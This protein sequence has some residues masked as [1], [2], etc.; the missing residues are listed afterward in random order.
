MRR[1]RLGG[2]LYSSPSIHILRAAL[3]PRQLTRS[4]LWPSQK[5][6]SIREALTRSYA[7]VVY[8]LLILAA[9]GSTDPVLG[10]RRAVSEAR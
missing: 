6:S 8:S 9:L 5:S 7:P 4:S 10:D 3:T 2:Y 1:I